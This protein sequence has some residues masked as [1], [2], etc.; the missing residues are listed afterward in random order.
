MTER[1]APDPLRALEALGDLAGMLDTV[2]QTLL[3]RGWSEAGAEQ[4]AITATQGALAILAAR[5]KPE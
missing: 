3:A 1:G 2:K 5:S 4:G